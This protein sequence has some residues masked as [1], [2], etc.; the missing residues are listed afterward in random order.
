[1]PGFAVDTSSHV[2]YFPDRGTVSLQKIGEA[3]GTSFGNL[4]LPGSDGPTTSFY[5]PISGLV[6]A[7]MGGLLSS[8]GTQ[9][10]LL[11]PVGDTLGTPINVGGDPGYYG[12]DSHRGLL[13]VGNEGTDNVS[14]I[15]ATTN[16][17]VG[18]IP[19]PVGSNPNGV[20]V[21]PVTGDVFVA[22]SSLNQVQEFG[23]ESCPGCYPVTF[24]QSSLPSGTN[25]S[26][27]LNGVRHDSAGASIALSEPSGSYA[28]LVGSA[29]LYTPFP[30]AGTLVVVAAPVSQTVIYTRTPPGSFLVAFTE[31]GL[32]SDTP[33]SV[34]LNNATVG[35]SSGAVLFVSAP[36]NLLFMVAPAQNYRPD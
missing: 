24:A 13:Y 19:L 18:A 25:W 17:V 2:I 10:F 15:N 6:Y 23:L 27:T 3:N 16:V 29:G 34:T 28:F 1:G 32:P 35:S 4:S 11:N 14:V 5:D 8:E 7:M 31:S 26:V 12:Y 20:T 33:W 36:G 9:V 30:S 21:D 22:E